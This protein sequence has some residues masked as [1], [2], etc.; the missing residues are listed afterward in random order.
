M[1]KINIIKTMKEFYQNHKK[2]TVIGI[3]IFVLVLIIFI[4]CIFLNSPKVINPRPLGFVG[5][6]SFKSSVA[7]R[8][9][10]VK[11]EISATSQNDLSKK[12]IIKNGSLSVVVKNIERTIPD[13][14]K[15]AESAGGFVSYS[16]IYET[17]NDKK[18]GAVTLRVP[19]D[20]FSVSLDKI[21]S[22]AVKVSSESTNTSD[23]TEQFVDMELRLKNMKAE[24]TQYLNIMK[25]AV[26]IED[27]LNVTKRL[28]D[29][30]GRIERLEGQIK[31]LS[32]QIDMSTITVSITSEANVEVFGIVWSPMSVI[33]QGVRNSLQ[34][35]VNFINEI[36]ALIFMLPVILLWIAFVGVLLWTGWKG[37]VIMRRR[38]FNN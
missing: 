10:F 2:S 38:Y 34:G 37:I 5:N 31:Y 8:G 30:R 24:E 16:K 35:V 23:V 18:S 22:L 12:K 36:I 28:S 21:K 1:I 15:I 14:K 32:R 13:I 6:S 26:K 4:V 29:V 20:K 3:S 17:G 9:I 27:V 33:K 7:S 19:A 11:S 25:R